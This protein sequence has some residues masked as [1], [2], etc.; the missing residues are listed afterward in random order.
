MMDNITI[1]QYVPGKSW[2]YR[3]D[4]RIKILLM[5]GMMVVIFLIPNIYVMLG[6]LGGFFIL[7]LT[8]RVPIIKMIKGFRPILYL[9]LFTFVLQ[10]IYNSNGK[11]LYEFN[12]TIGLFQI[13]CM[14]AILTLWFFTKKYIPIKFLYFLVMITGV[15]AVQLIPFKEFNFAS[16]TYQ[17]YDQGVIK[18]TFIFIRVIL[19]IGLT[20]LLTF[21]T[22]NTDINNGFEALLSPLKLIKIPVG[23]FAMMLSLT[24]RFIPTLVD[25]ANR[26][27]KAQASRGVDFN[28]GS[29]KKKIRQIVSLLVP[30]FVISFRRAE[31]LANA[32]EARGYIVGGKRTKLDELKLHLVDY[33][34][35]I[36]YAIVLAGVICARIY[37]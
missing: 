36:G 9:M 19:M 1:G 21:T 14:V 12:F 7:V 31:E 20:S 6:T 4:P 29:L 24:L 2:I 5:I 3:M 37:L 27:M 8:T 23:V 25:E 13:L 35:M 30:M 26:I 11:L 34:S 28:E 22:M 33:L 17:I 10:T 16:Y 15:F 18:G 32:M